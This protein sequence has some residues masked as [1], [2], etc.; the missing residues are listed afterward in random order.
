L[1]GFTWAL[2]PESIHISFPLI[3]NTQGFSQ[4]FQS[5]HTPFDR[6]IE[7]PQVELYLLNNLLYFAAHSRILRQGAAAHTT[8]RAHTL[9]QEAQ[10]R[11]V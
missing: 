11:A 6:L 7:H 2:I 4:A 5:E 1:A 3:H 9:L 8:A 10:R